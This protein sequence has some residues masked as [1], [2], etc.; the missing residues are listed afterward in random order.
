MHLRAYPLV[1]GEKL[2]VELGVGEIGRSSFRLNYRIVDKHGCERATLETVHVAVENPRA[3][4][5]P[6]PGSLRQALSPYQQEQTQ[7]K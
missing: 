4:P 6:L 7:V 1:H 2:T 5:V 3:G